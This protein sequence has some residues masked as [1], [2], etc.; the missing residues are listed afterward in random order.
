MKAMAD[1]KQPEQQNN[2]PIE[3]NVA[4]KIES[5]KLSEHVRR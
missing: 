3:K 1:D 5:G 2:E 4:F